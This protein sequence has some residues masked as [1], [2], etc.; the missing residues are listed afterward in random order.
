MFFLFSHSPKARPCHCLLPG[1]WYPSGA[2]I[3][4]RPP[5]ALLAERLLS[6]HLNRQ[7]KKGG[8]AH[9]LWGSISQWH[10]I[11]RTVSPC[12][13]T[14]PTLFLLSLPRAGTHSE[15]PRDSCWTDWW[16]N[17]QVAWFDLIAVQASHSARK[18]FSANDSCI[19]WHRCPDRNKKSNSNQ[20][21]ACKDQKVTRCGKDI[22]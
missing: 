9:L 16:M 11:E 15:W 1:V 4:R 19:L 18:K 6:G 10:W 22:D 3:Y 12:G 7:L 2:S 17:A 14:L 5:R 8:R 20:P 21:V 13:T